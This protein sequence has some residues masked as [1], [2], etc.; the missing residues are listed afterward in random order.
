[1]AYKIKTNVMAKKEIVITDDVFTIDLNV[2][3]YLLIVKNSECILTLAAFS[4]PADYDKFNVEICNVSGG[5]IKIMYEG[6]EDSL[7]LKNDNSCP[8]I[9]NLES[10][11][12]V[13]YAG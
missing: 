9:G 3:G 12:D 11:Y 10:G 6:T 1:M 13:L 8:V 5:D 4:S 7:I 2:T